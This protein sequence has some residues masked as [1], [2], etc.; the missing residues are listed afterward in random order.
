MASSK[1]VLTEKFLASLKPADK[2]KR[3][4]VDDA[5]VPGLAAATGLL[6]PGSRTSERPCARAS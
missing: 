2:G 5:L 6:N 1:K 4:A 3:Y